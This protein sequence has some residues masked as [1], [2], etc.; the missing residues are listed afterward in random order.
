MVT[1]AQNEALTRVGDKIMWILIGG[2]RGIQIL[3]LKHL[4]QSKYAWL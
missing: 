4:Q 1:L 3:Y 2:G